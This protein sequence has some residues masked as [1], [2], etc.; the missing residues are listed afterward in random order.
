MVLVALFL[1]GAGWPGLG[2]Q[3]PV[4]VQTQASEAGTGFVAVTAAI[5][6]LLG[7]WVFDPALLHTEAYRAM[8]ERVRDLA[9]RVSTRE[10][11]VAQ[12][13][14]AWREGPFSHVQA[15]VMRANAEQTATYLDTMRVGGKGARLAW[16]GDVAVLTVDTMMGTDTIEQIDA[17]F[18]ELAGRRSRGLV[19]D[20]RANEGGAFAGVALVGHLIDAPFDAGAFVS[21][22]WAS[23]MQRPP[24]RA[25][26]SE[27]SPWTGWALTAFWRDVLAARLTPIQFQPKSPRYDGPVVLLVSSKTASAAEMTADA[28]RG[29]GR[30]SIV[31]ERTAGRM[32]SQKIYDLP[33]GLQ[34]L[35]PIA[36]YYSWSSGRIEGR[37]VM[38]DWNVPAASALEE[39]ERR[40]AVQ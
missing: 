27:V 32:L 18:D 7:R 25:D 19:V 17:A 10:E 9:G 15:Q 24:L 20:L 33:Q 16:R 2:A 1:V 31:G 35:L 34:L 11:F 29:A 22:R 38:P 6:D 28:I 37:G 30:A 5:D 23:T 8:Q 39:A 40:L 21:Q 13:N 26:V 14:A 3:A 12:F 36:D 4:A